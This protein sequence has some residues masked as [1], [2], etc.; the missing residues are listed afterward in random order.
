MTRKKM[1]NFVPKKHLTIPYKNYA[2]KKNAYI[3]AKKA[4]NTTLQKLCQENNAQNREK[5]ST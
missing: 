2:K 5:Q 4:P 3:Q 1:P